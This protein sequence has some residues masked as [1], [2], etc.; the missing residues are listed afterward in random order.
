M[1]T[2]KHCVLT[3][4][5]GFRI[6]YLAS[7]SN[8][9]SDHSGYWKHRLQLFTTSEQSNS[10]K[11]CITDTYLPLCSP[12]TMG[13]CKSLLKSAHFCGVTWL[14]CNLCKSYMWSIQVSNKH[15]ALSLGIYL[16]RNKNWWNEVIISTHN[17]NVTNIP[18]SLTARNTNSSG[19]SSRN[20]SF[21][22]VSISTFTISSTIT[23]Q[24][25]GW[26]VTANHTIH[27]QL[28]FI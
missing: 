27:F 19:E 28:R 20:N 1:Q 16:D 11:G 2:L 7:D 23:S 22:V 24:R 10:A 18:L 4:Q 13:Q 12:Y 9:T 25:K 17:K 21:V 15:K 5:A 26:P 3:S 14:I 8:Q 6:P